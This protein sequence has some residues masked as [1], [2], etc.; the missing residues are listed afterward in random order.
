[1]GLKVHFFSYGCPRV[2]NSNFAKFFDELI[3][4]TNIRAVYKN[5][6]VPTLPGSAFGF[7]H[8]GQEVHFYDCEAYIAYPDNFEDIPNVAISKVKDHS[9]YRCL[10][11]VMEE[12]FVY[13]PL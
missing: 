9:S 2:G 8:A 11:D 13:K 10:D 4:E 1:M 5:D 6:P 7:S 3:T 12:D